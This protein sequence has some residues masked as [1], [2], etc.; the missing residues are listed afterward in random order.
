MRSREEVLRGF[1][2]NPLA[3]YKELEAASNAMADRIRELEARVPTGHTGSDAA[4]P[5]GETPSSSRIEDAQAVA[6]RVVYNHDGNPSEFV[7]AE[8]VRYTLSRAAPVAA[9]VTPITAYDAPS[10]LKGED[11]IVWAHGYNAAL[12]ATQGSVST[13][14]GLTASRGGA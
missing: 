14:G 6:W 12:R 4:P 1:G 8:G 3:S 2:A 9:V 5:R 7:D 11:A 10:Y 13:E